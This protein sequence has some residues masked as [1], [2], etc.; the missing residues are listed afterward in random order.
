[1]MNS[2]PKQKAP[3]PD[4]FA[5]K[6]YEKFKEDII[7]IVYNFSQKTETEEMLPN[8]SYEANSTTQYQN[9]TTILQEK[10]TAGQYFS[11]T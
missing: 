11:W 2:L 4:R 9:Q 5:G 10:K 3:G 1:M 6:F 8:S 7:L